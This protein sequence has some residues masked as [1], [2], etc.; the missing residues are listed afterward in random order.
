MTGNVNISNRAELGMDRRKPFCL[1]RTITVGRPRS[2]DFARSR[3]AC[4]TWRDRRPVLRRT[5]V[6]GRL[7][8]RVTNDCGFTQCRVHQQIEADSTRQQD[9]GMMAYRMLITAE[10]KKIT[11]KR[12]GKKPRFEEVT[13]LLGDPRLPDSCKL[14]GRSTRKILRPS[15]N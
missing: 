3:R 2:L 8:S 14:T 4:R 5:T 12:A 11:S 9:L 13:V 1:P 10:S 7:D 15:T 6:L